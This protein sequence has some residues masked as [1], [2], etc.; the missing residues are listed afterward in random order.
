MKT[1]IALI[2]L[3]I[4]AFIL[5]GCVFSLYPLYT[6]ND[7]VYDNNLE[8][9]WGDTSKNTWKFENLMQ[10][11]MAPYKNKPEREKQEIIKGQLINK[12]TYLLTCTE[13][14]E[15]RKMQAHLTQLDDNLFLDIFPDD[16]NLKNS[17]F[18][19]QFVPVHTYA[20]VKIT[21]NR[22]EL[23]FLNTDLMDKLLEQ[24]T[25]RIKYEKLNNYKVITA[26]TE[27][28]QKFIKKYANRRD[29]FNDAAF[30]TKKA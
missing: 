2:L 23:Y 12:K 30:L 8:G 4:G 9:V 18:E 19:T 1:K 3:L 25:I 7:L 14:G 17:F 20:K 28:L 10:H 26:S 11:E 6:E 16:L 27:E 15:A 22:F 5:P 21:G 29:L 13:N 24:N